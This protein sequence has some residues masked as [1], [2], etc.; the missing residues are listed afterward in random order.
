MSPTS[1]TKLGKRRS[2]GKS[3]PTPPLYA[4]NNLSNHSQQPCIVEWNSVHTRTDIKQETPRR[5]SAHSQPVQLQ[6]LVAWIYL[7]L[8]WGVSF[9]KSYVKR[10]FT[11]DFQR[12]GLAKLEESNKREGGGMM[13]D[14]RMG[15]V[16]KAP[17][18][19][20]G[21]SPGLAGLSANN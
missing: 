21:L 13:P 14:K 19:T 18:K 7:C 12:N 6:P 16:R 1:G 9:E 2:D 20:P 4:V 3:A 17:R 15:V 8:Y 10:P 11:K 5:L